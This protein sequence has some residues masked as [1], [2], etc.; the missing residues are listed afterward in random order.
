MPPRP[1]LVTR[2]LRRL[3]A[4]F[5][6][7]FPEPAM[8]SHGRLGSFPKRQMK[9]T[10]QIWLLVLLISGA[11]LGCGGEPTKGV[12]KGKDMPIP[13]DPLPAEKK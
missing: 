9:R 10:L 7:S 3:L 13:A 12:N 8:S 11:A 4:F 5:A 1:R 2:K 6:A